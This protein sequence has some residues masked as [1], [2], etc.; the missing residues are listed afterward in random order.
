MGTKTYKFHE[1][2]DKLSQVQGK[3][4]DD[5]EKL[6]LKMIWNWIKQRH[7]DFADFSA[8]HYWM[9]MNLTEKVS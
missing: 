3:S 2:I 5:T 8:L 7:I 6:Q 4:D 1:L 9:A